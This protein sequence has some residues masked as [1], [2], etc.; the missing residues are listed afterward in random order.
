MKQKWLAET[1]R[2]FYFLFSSES[3]CDLLWITTVLISL[4]GIILVKKKIP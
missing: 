2:N 3:H 1:W 4:V